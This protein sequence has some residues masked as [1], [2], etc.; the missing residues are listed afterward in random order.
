MVTQYQ[1]KERKETEGKGKVRR[2]ITWGIQ[3]KNKSNALNVSASN[4]RFPQS[5]S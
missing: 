4:R 2:I 1:H 3:K 5:G